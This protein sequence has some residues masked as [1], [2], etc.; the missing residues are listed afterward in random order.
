MNSFENDDELKKLLE[1]GI[2]AVDKPQGPTSHQ[3]T[4]WVGEMLGGDIR[5]GHGGTLDPMV[6]G[7]LIIMLGRAVRLAPVILK[8][9][10]EY[11][12]IMRLH[13]DVP[14]KEIERV[15]EEF[16]GRTYQRPPRKSAVR[17]QLRIRSIYDIEVLDVD[18]RLVLL[19]VDCE[20]GT[21]IRS[22]CIHMALAL[23]VGGQMEELR[24]SKSGGLGLPD[25][26]TLHDLKDACEFAKEGDADLLKS[27]IYPAERLISEIPVVTIRNSAVDAIC[28][29]AQLAGVGIIARDNYKKGSRVAVMTEKSELV[30]L[31]E[32]L[33]SSEEYKPGDTGIVI[34][35][36]I[37]VMKPKTYKKGWTKHEKSE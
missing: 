15:A 5:I 14:R 2:I 31:G 29:G 24:R 1:C 18:K 20:A 6:S 3:V 7:V 34:D 16:K 22:L 19:R 36:K 30:C 17:R 13:G 35:P 32:A 25:I 23:G 8:H 26:C 37:V 27:F 33:I 9:R 12:A 28:H 4:A 11:I 10:K 21:Y